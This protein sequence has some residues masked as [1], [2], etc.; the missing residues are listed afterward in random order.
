MCVCEGETERES[1]TNGLAVPMEGV[2][3]FSWIFLSC[4]QPI[5]TKYNLK[6]HF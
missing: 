5:I 1:P 6:K 2:A 3:W 4:Q